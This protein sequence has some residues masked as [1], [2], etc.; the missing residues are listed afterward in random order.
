M[1]FMTSAA[2][3]A[4][5]LLTAPSATG[6]FTS[7]D[8]FPEPAPT[9]F[10]ISGAALPDGRLLVWNGA[11]LFVQL[12]PNVDFFPRAASGYAGD[13]GFIAL[14]PSGNT[15]ILGAGFSGELYRVSTDAIE[16]FSQDVIIDAVPHFSGVM[17]TNDLLLLDIGRPDFSGAD[18]QIANINTKSGTLR[19]KPVA[20]RPA[21]ASKA[22]VVVPKPPFAFSSDL[23]I[24]R[25]AGLVYAMDAN[26]RELRSFAVSD[27]I[28]AFNNDMMLDWTT[29]G[30]P[31]GSPG[32]FLSGGVAGIRP[33]G[34][35]IIDGAEFFGG[36]TAVQLVDPDTASI[37]D[38]LTPS[39]TTGF[40]SV[41]YNEV[42][43]VLSIF[44]GGEAVS[45]AELENVPAAG[46]AGLALLT[47][48]MLAA[49]IRLR[50][51]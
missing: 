11:D 43:D 47:G 49:G 1:K 35:L 10:G 16:D 2:L 24:D 9:A 17:L 5:L 3:A 48:A 26:P 18:L 31:I 19:W 38:T 39:G 32:D 20:A 28:D 22:E 45:T 30:T 23:A 51:Q 21:A 8:A 14:T 34:T 50:R 42:T 44:N 40:Y 25:G 37:I 36:P 27:L 6:Q 15:A 4:T 29:D 46:A 33:D 7:Y 13:P 41:I 12:E